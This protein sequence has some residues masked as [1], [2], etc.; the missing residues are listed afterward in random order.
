MFNQRLSTVP[1]CGS[2][3]AIDLAEPHPAGG[4]LT[5]GPIPP[6][7][8]EAPVAPDDFRTAMRQIPAAVTVVTSSALGV[9][10]GLT[11]TAVSSVSAAPPQVLVCV[12]RATR[13]SAAISVAGRFG[14]NYLGAE[15]A[16]L[17][18]A[19]AAPTGDPEDR[20]RRAQ[21]SDSPSGTPLLLD[22]LVAF[23]C[24]VI[25]EIHSGTHAIFVGQVTN[26]RCR[27]GR[28]LIYQRG[29]F[30]SPNLS[31]STSWLAP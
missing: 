19:F 2:I 16:E 7:S 29:A 26:V 20:F 27:E 4:V 28:S 17:A 25:N 22:A 5:E 6:S 18:E 11:A 31:A 3:S 21:W 23:E 1:P 30:A 14:L 10:H 8:S 15:H 13:S 9:H 12:N 24:I